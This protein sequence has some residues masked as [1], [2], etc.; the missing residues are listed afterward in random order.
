MVR[1]VT[2]A[3]VAKAA[4]VSRQLVSLVVRGDKRVSPQR[5]T[6]VLQAIEELGY[7]PNA[8]AQSLASRTTN[9]L[10][11][12]VPSFENSFYGEFAEAFTRACARRGL[13][14]LVNVSLS[15]PNREQEAIDRFVELRVDGLALISPLIDQGVLQRAAD[16]M[17]V[18]LVSNNVA[19]QNVDL[20]H[21]NDFEGARSCALHLLDQGYRDVVFLGPFRNIKGDTTYE[22]IYGYRAAMEQRGRRDDITVIIVDD[23]ADVAAREVLD[24]FGA[25]TGIVCHNDLLAVELLMAIHNRGLV[26]GAH[27]GVTGFDNTRLAYMPELSLTSVDQ[28][29]EGLAE[30]SVSVL[31]ERLDNP[32]APQ[33]DIVLE[34]RLMPRGSSNPHRCGEYGPRSLPKTN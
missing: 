7:R 22:R 5:R 26:P 13:T 14:A 28:Q 3:D 21:T 19:P 29:L 34:P 16:E 23:R 9:N 8:A 4:G 31:M 18:C 6:A 17:S 33:R 32:D 24:E 30:A 27:V 1:R 2:Q 10:G 25:D 15:D 11:L 12:L 20:V